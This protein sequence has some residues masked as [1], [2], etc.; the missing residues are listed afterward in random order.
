MRPRRRTPRCTAG[1]SLLE[2][3]VTLVILTLLFGGLMLPLAASSDMRA[4]QETDK[5]LADIRDALI[6]FAVANG[7]LPC[8]A[9]ATLPS[10]TGSAGAEARDAAGCTCAGTASETAAIS[11]TPC[12]SANDQDGVSGVLPWAALG[13]PETDAWGRRYTYRINAKFGRAPGQ[14]TFGSGC[15]P[16]QPPARAGF[17]LC[18]PG[19][20]AVKSGAGGA[21]LVT[22]GVPAVVLSHGRNGLG[23]Y[24]PQ[25]TRIAPN[26]ASADELENA[27]GDSV[28]VANAASDD[29]VVWVPAALLMQ[30]MVS[31]GVLP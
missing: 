11:A 17:A 13:L 1:F 21:T 10:G 14:D 2:L 22:G 31:A 5:A 26:G 20:V 3:A 18:T 12:R 28:F 15:S 8:P 16:N 7:R 4:R 9:A 30:R 27:N 29:Q 19:G 23:A 25:G 6:G 24:M